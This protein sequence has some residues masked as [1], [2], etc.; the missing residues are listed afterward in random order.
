MSES[1]KGMTKT[2]SI[3]AK[4]EA[5][6]H[7]M[8]LKILKVFRAGGIVQLKKTDA[9][10]NDWSPETMEKIQ[11]FLKTG[12][13]ETLGSVLESSAMTIAHPVVFG[14]L[15]H[16]GQLVRKMDEK[17]RNELEAW[18]ASIDLDEP[19]IPIETK[20]AA[21]AALEE[22]LKTWVPKILPGFTIE[23]MKIPKRKGP[24]TKYNYLDQGV[25]L[26]EFFQLEQ[27]M[28]KWPVMDFRPKA[29]ESKEEFLQRTMKLVQKVH[30]QTPYSLET[31]RDPDAPKEDSTKEF[32]LSSLKH[33]WIRRVPLP[34]ETAKEVAQQ[35]IQKKRVSKKELLYALFRHYYRLKRNTIR[36]FVEGA[37][38]K[39]YT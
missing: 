31:Y 21:K 38:P 18:G 25:L 36:K 6:L 7:P 5:L 9:I 1:T 2:K 34:K 14:Q 35:G 30:E 39:H 11:S 15:I 4:L 20:Q 27:K 24:K 16:L 13:L 8:N 23:R 26:C 3:N 28:K 22:L 10:K 37:S 17:T 32:N 29:K 12:N 19:T 33:W